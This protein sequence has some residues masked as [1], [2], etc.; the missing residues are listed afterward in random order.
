MA[1]LS[2]DGEQIFV[3]TEGTAHFDF[4]AGGAPTS[5]AWEMQGTGAP[6]VSP[7]PG[8]TIFGG[9]VSALDPATG[10]IAWQANAIQQVG[11]LFGR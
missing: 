2:Y 8:S 5:T 7:Y 6:G 4:R 9:N 11:A 3:T 1:G 10:Q